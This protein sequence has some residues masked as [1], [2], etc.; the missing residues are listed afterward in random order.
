[1]QRSRT[2]GTYEIVRP[3]SN[4]RPHP[5]SSS[6][7]LPTRRRRG[8]FRL[9]RLGAPWPPAVAARRRAR[10]GPRDLPCGSPHQARY[11]PPRQAGRSDRMERA[12]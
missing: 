6:T 9:D 11:W 3:R 7:R 10:H 8:Q 1:M 5:P 12:A 4:G 2:G